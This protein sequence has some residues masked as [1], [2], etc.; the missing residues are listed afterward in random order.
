MRHSI[1]DGSTATAPHAL[2]ISR[3]SPPASKRSPINHIAPQNFCRLI[4]LPRPYLSPEGTAK[5]KPQRE[6]RMTRKKLQK[7][8][9]DEFSQLRMPAHANPAVAAC[10]NAWR[11]AYCEVRLKSQSIDCAKAHARMAFRLAM[12]P[13]AGEENLHDFVACIT[14]G[15]LF[16]V[17]G[18]A[19]GAKFLYAV[20]VTNSILRQAHQA[21][22]PKKLAPAPVPLPAEDAPSLAQI[23]AAIDPGIETPTPPPGSFRTSPRARP[24]PAPDH[25]MSEGKKDARAE[26]RLVRSTARPHR[27]SE[28]LPHPRRRIVPAAR[29]GRRVPWGGRIFQ[30]SSRNFAPCARIAHSSQGAQPITLRTRQIPA[31]AGPAAALTPAATRPHFPSP[32]ATESG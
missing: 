31:G 21:Q 15:M 29:V 25:K 6:P 20:Q 27:R 12:P 22:R 1:R 16:D 11:L 7:Y 8:V 17:I 26:R 18:T 9:S 19:E 13:L 24:Q 4:P 5:T 14:F 28:R 23:Q 3:A 10:A 2:S 30:K 32:T